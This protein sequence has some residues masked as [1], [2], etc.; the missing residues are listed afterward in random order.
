GATFKYTV[1]DGHG[2]TGEGTI[3]MN[4]VTQGGIGKGV[5]VSGGSATIT[6]LGI[7]GIEYDLQRATVSVNGPYTTV[8]AAGTQIPATDGD[9]TF[10][11]TDTTAS[12]TIAFYRS[13]QH[14]EP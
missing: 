11:F 12:G 6:F 8:T 1:S 9:G 2:S 3:T 4:V 7:P 13:I 5:T 10:T 14:V